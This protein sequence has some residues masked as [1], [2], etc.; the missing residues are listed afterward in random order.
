MD[1]RVN[2]Q[3]RIGSRIGHGSTGAVHRGTDLST[4]EEVAIKLEYLKGRHS[5]H[6]D[7]EARCY[8]AMTGKEGIPRLRWFG[9]EC[10]Y[11]VLVID[12]L[13]SNLEELH[14]DLDRKFTLSTILKLAMQMISRVEALHGEGFVHCDIKPSNFAVGRGEQKQVIFL[15]DF[16]LAK[17]YRD[18]ETGQHVPLR[19][20]SYAGTDRYSSINTHLGYSPTRRDDIES[21]GYSILYFFNGYLPWQSMAGANSRHKRTRIQQKKSSMSVEELCRGLPLMADFFRHVRELKFDE[22]PDY[23]YLRRLFEA[24]FERKRYRLEEDWDWDRPPPPPSQNEGD[25]F[26]WASSS[27]RRSGSSSSQQK[28]KYGRSGGAPR[29]RN[30]AVA[31]AIKGHMQR[32]FLEQLGVIPRGN[33]FHR[34]AAAANSGEGAE[35]TEGTEGAAEKKTEEAPPSPPKLHLIPLTPEAL[36][37]L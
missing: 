29:E 2:N 31:E 1:V 3:Y 14:L 28:D 9:R 17:R 37:V 8:E 12:L 33:A 24:L 36:E 6:L 35:G 19:R 21:L 11:N 15:I 20:C 26:D 23:A 13:G 4:G 25:R 16:G 5:L 18:P 7:L 30:P 22:A 27:W 34:A 32:L 10:D